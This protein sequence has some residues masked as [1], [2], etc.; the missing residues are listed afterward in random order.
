MFLFES[1]CAFDEN[2]YDGNRNENGN[3]NGEELGW[4]RG[5]KSE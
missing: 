1:N 2:E 5:S 3:G 4:D